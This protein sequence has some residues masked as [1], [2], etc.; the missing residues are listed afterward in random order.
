MAIAEPTPAIIPRSIILS[1]ANSRSPWRDT[2]N[3]PLATSVCTRRSVSLKPSLRRLACAAP[4]LPSLPRLAQHRREK[5]PGIASR[6]LD[7]I[8]GRAPGDDFAAAVAAF[9]AE[10]DHPVGGFDHFE[11]VLDHHHGVALRYQ[12]VQYLEQ[13]F[14]VVEMQAGGRLVEDIQRAAGGAF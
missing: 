6:R 3:S 2:S 7:D 8:L 12:L 11:I 14:D 9:G 10:V 5:L 1:A 4:A 13:F